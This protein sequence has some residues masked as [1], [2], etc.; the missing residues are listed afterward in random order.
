LL[1]VREPAIGL[2]IECSKV[3]L[4]VTQEELS[5][6]STH[7]RVLPIGARRRRTSGAKLLLAG[8][9]LGGG[10]GLPAMAEEGTADERRACTP[11]VFRLCGEFIPN[12]DRITACLQEKVRDLSPACRVVFTPSR[13]ARR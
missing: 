6:T 8:L 13:A 11:D 3:G 12:A 1:R 2:L 4:S 7:R 9:L 10:A 5:M